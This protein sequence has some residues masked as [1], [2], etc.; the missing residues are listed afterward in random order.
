M[1]DAQLFLLFDDDSRVEIDWITNHIKGL[2]LY[3]AAISSGQSISKAGQALPE[4][5]RY[6]RVSDLLDTGNVLIKREVFE[7]I[8]LFDPILFLSSVSSQN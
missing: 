7:G 1:S 6:F 8:G 5:Y 3:D 4:N 2:D